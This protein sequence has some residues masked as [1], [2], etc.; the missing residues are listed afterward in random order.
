MTDK[1]IALVLGAGGS[2]GSA[3]H[4][5]VLSML[6]EELGW[7]PRRAGL[8]VGT[9]AGSIA[10][11]MLRAGMPAAD[12]ANRALG[13]P[14]T[15]EGGAVVRRA[16]LGAPRRPEFKRPDARSGMASRTRLAAAARRPWSASPGSLL[17]AILPA[18]QVPT[19]V[20]AAPMEALFG[21]RWPAAPYYAVAVDLDS[22]R[23]TVFGKEGEPRATVSQAVRASC[24]IP[25]FFAPVEIGG[26]RYVDGGVHSTTNADVVAGWKPDLV[27]VSV[28]MSAARGAGRVSADGAVRRFARL[29]LAREAAKLRR[30]GIPVVAFSPSAAD[31]EVMA[32]DALDPRKQPPVCTSAQATT[33]RRLQ[34]A[35][36]RRRLAALTA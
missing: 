14:L 20:M 8:I 28:P 15:A 35:D 30:A 10:G 4:A 29:S 17:A 7:D 36:V 6:H 13:A 27:V 23:R 26:R 32:G 31:L 21:D 3:F 5:G 12:L 34:R 33:R 9:S 22:G 25:A 19:E 24:A 2:V 18:G 1:R 11:A 16:M